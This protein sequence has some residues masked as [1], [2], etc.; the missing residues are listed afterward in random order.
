MILHI[1][2]HRTGKSNKNTLILTHASTIFIETFT[3]L[4][5]I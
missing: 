1:E 4:R 2:L 5:K 3:T